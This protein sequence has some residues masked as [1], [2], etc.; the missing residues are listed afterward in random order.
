[1]DIEHLEHSIRKRELLKLLEIEKKKFNDNY[2]KYEAERKKNIK[3]R[4][5]IKKT[6]PT[7][8]TN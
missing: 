6:K 3:K 5:V 4:N 8:P 7:D 2:K 1:M